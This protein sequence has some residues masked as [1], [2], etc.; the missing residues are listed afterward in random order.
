MLESITA[1]MAREK[2]ELKAAAVER[3]AGKGNNFAVTMG[4]PDAQSYAPYSTTL[5]IYK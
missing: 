1:R 2:E 4:K 3:E 5:R